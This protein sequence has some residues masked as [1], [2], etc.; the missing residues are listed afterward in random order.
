VIIAMCLEVL[1]FLMYFLVTATAFRETVDAVLPEQK[2]LH[3]NRL[4]TAAAVVGLRWGYR[5]SIP[6]FAISA[7]TE[8]A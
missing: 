3:Y 8:P 4:S 5:D 6:S 1:S 7:T 2:G